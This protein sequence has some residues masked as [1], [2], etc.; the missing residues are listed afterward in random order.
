M[1][2][3]KASSIKSVSRIDQPHKKHHGYYVRVCF[4]GEKHSK[5]FSD[6]KHN[7]GDE[8]LHAAVQWRNQKE[9]EIGKPRTDRMVIA[10]PDDRRL[11]VRR[12]VETTR[13]GEKVYEYSAYEVTWCPEPG[14]VKRKRFFVNTYGE[15]GAKEE[16][17]RFRRAQEIKMYGQEIG[18]GATVVEKEEEKEGE[19][20]AA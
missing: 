1:A 9:K 5:F 13:R 4:K 20:V 7:G 12:I 10:A 17:Y 18:A 8:A 6:K 2:R 11:G 15:D 19:A 14:K 3:V 16:A